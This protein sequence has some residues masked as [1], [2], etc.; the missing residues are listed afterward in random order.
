MAFFKPP[1]PI[2]QKTSPPLGPPSAIISELPL[3]SD[4]HQ[5]FQIN[6]PRTPKTKSELIFL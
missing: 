2:G 4:G 3:S 1:T 6:S 5:T